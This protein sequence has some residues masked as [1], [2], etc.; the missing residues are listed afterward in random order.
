MGRAQPIS[1]ML[2]DDHEIVREG[3]REILEH[4]GEFEVV[5]QAADGEAAVEVA[6]RVNPDVI[7]MDVMMPVKNGIDACREIAD[8]LPDTRLL[9]LT[10]AAEEDAMMEAVAAGATG[11]LQK[12]SGKEILLRTLR[13]VAAG[14]YTI[15]A[16]VIR[17]V[18][19]GLRAGRSQRM[20]YDPERL[21]PRERE[22]LALFAQGK[23]YAM[24]AAVRGNQPVTI[25]NAIYGIQDKLDI[26]T[27]QELAVWAVRSGLLDEPGMGV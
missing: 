27:K 5:G 12:H 10:A 20:M 19:A 2:V 4:S 24:I 6:Q 22:I 9:I 13:E 26:D 11:Y 23:S 17:R 1:V 21:T 3:L 8:I 15:P 14:E 7:V 25:R 18:L 16:D